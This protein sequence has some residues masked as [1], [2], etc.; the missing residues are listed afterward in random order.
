MKYSAILGAHDVFDKNA[1]TDVAYFPD[2]IIIHPNFNFATKAFDVAL[3]EFNTTIQFTNEIK[4]ICLA[5][6]PGAE[7][8]QVLQIAGWG[9]TMGPLKI[10]NILQ[11]TT[12]TVDCKSYCELRSELFITDTMFCA[13]GK[14]SGFCQRDYGGPAFTTYD[15]PESNFIQYGII[16]FGDACINPNDPGYYTDVSSVKK[17]IQKETNSCLC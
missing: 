4:P 2:R 13:T 16:S 1:N 10:T 3:L 9:V 14:D 11:K 12:V 17:W 8:L 5:E 7:A 15:G 6:P